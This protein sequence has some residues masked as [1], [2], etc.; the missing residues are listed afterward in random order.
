MN[1]I[2]TCCISKKY[3]EKLQIFYFDGKKLLKELM[4]RTEILK[5][6]LILK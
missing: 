4:Y 6:I 2:K 5:L 3:G 1:Y